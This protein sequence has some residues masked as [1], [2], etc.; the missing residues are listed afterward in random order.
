MSLKQGEKKQITKH[1]PTIGMDPLKPKIKCQILLFITKSNTSPTEHPS[2][3][4]LIL[5][6]KLGLKV[7]DLVIHM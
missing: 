6:Q 2:L 1:R 7:T 5:T 4:E 3:P